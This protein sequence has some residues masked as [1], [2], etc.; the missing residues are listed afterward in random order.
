MRPVEEIEARIH[1]LAIEI[2]ACQQQIR[3]VNHNDPEDYAKVKWMRLRRN[4]L[5]IER[6]MLQWATEDSGVP[7]K[8]PSPRP[9]T[10]EQ[11]EA[12]TYA[13]EKGHRSV[14]LARL[15]LNDAER[16]LASCQASCAEIIPQ[17][18]SE[19]MRTAEEVRREIVRLDGMIAGLSQK[20]ADAST[21]DQYEAYRGDR[22]RLCLRRTMLRWVLCKRDRVAP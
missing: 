1:S 10:E 11:M 14:Q 16:H 17:V 21:N 7:P 15:D 8:T 19:P 6:Q 9:P 2:D 3:Q 20:M 5:R 4:R 18:P 13:L 22:R 12:L